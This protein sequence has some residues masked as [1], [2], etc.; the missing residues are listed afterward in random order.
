MNEFTRYLGFL[1]ITGLCYIIFLLIPDLGTVYVLAPVS[2]VM[3]RYAGGKPYY[4]IV[5]TILGIFGM[6]LA[7]TQFSHIRDRLDYYLYPDKYENSRE[8]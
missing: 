7:A 4:L 5:T 3:F 8:I 6:F 2:M 1:I